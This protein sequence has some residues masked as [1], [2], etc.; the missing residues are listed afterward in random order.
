LAQY[1]DHL[2]IQSG[3]STRAAVHEPST[4]FPGEVRRDDDRCHLASA[5]SAIVVGEAGG[6]DERAYACVRGPAITHAAG[7][8]KST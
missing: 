6:A 2:G 4:R 5:A 7:D 8:V 1:S 3:P